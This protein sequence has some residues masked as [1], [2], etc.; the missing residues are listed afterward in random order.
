M[1][2]PRLLRP[3]AP[4]PSAVRAT[5]WKQR[6]VRPVARPPIPRPHHPM[7][8]QHLS[9]TLPPRSH[10]SR[11]H[12]PQPRRRFASNAA[13]HSPKLP[14]NSAVTAAHLFTDHVRFNSCLLLELRRAAHTRQRVLRSMRPPHWSGAIRAVTTACGCSVRTTFC[15]RDTASRCFSSS[16]ARATKLLEGPSHDH[17]HRGGRR[18]RRR[19]RSV[20]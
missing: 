13:N 6:F 7:P 5:P 19:R 18:A 14:R 8:P 11:K 2:P 16:R 1:L 20:V 3:N 15:K 9:H 12:R 17:R 4:A 10:Q